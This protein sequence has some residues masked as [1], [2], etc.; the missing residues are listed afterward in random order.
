MDINRVFQ[1][2]Q[3]CTIINGVLLLFTTFV[4]MLMPNRIYRLHSR[5]FS[6][7]RDSFNVI[8]YAYLGLF[9]LFFIFFNLM[10]Y[11]VLILMT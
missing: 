3:W 8:V 5:C 1:F 7:S 4:I 2:F 11:L 10:P 9:K 6:L